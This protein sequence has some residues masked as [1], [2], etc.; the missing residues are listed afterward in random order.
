MTKILAQ[1]SNIGTIKI[2]QSSASSGSYDY[3]T[4][5]GFGETTALD[6]PER[7]RRHRAAPRHVVG[8]VDRAP[9]RSAR[10]SSVTPLQM[11]DGLQRDRQRRR[12]RGAQPGR[13]PPIDA[14]GQEHPTSPATPGAGWSPRPTADKMNLMLRN[15]VDRGH[16]HDGRGHGYTV[17][18]KTG[19]ARKPQP[20]RRLHRR[21]GVTQYQS[22]F[23]GFVPAEAP[24]LSIIVVIDEPAGGNYSGGAVAAPA[25]SKIASFALRQFAVPPPADRRRRRRRA[26]GAADRPRRRPPARSTACP[27]P[28]ARRRSAAAE[29][30][31][32]TTDA[33][34]RRRRQSTPATTPTTTTPTTAAEPPTT[35][36]TRP[37]RD[38]SRLIRG[39][40]DVDA[41][42]VGGDARRRRHVGRP[43]L[44]CRWRPGAPVLLRPRRARRRPRLRPRRG[45][46]R[47]GGRCSSSAPLALDVPQ[48]VVPDTRA[49]MAPLAVPRSTATRLERS[50]VVGVTGTN[51][52]TTTT[53]LLRAIFE[54][55]GRPTEVLGTLSGART[56][57]EAPELQRRL[58]ALR[59]AGVDGRGHGGVVAR[60]RPCTGS[61]APG[62]RSPCSPTSA[63]TTSTSTRRWRPT[64]RPRPACSS[65]TLRRS[66]RGQPRQPLRAPAARRRP[67]SPPSGY[68][69]DDVDGPRARR[70]GQPRSR[71]RGHAVDAR[72]SA[73]ASTWPTPWP[74]P[75]RPSRSGI[76]PRRRRRRALSRPIAVPGPLR[77]GRRRASR[78]RWWSTT[79]TRP[80]G[81][82]SC[83]SAARD[84]GRRRAGDR[85][86]RLRRRPR[87]HQAAADG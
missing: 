12:L 18:G 48:L 1:S 62:S 81:S 50:T 69:L 86:V 78:S 80:T 28:G 44:A 6:F 57:P 67:R 79:P 33:A 64:S 85:G 8:H 56:T 82:S 35:P 52:K 14:D 9:S 19:T 25:F 60:A 30:A 10:A 49:A 61:T 26:A 23:V 32:P 68:S 29:P 65:P 31:T 11:L 3:L 27:R 53:Y 40:P 37:A 38:A 34:R 71:W 45:R 76:D 41:R 20:E 70:R 2:A 46:G 47:R 87:R 42:G 22:T 5:F 83:S 74:R 72:R 66:G 77:A 59:D 58:A 54:A 39:L 73:A 17:A 15:V 75:R 7:G 36:T 63:A 21:D 51:G 4:A 55:A 24:A 43:R 16:R 13:L 84:A